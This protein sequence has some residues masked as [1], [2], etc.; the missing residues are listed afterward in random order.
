MILQF[1]LSLNIIAISDLITHSLTSS[2]LISSL[3]NLGPLY[4]Q[5]G[6]PARHVF[7][8][9]VAE[10]STELFLP[11]RI[12]LSDN[13]IQITETDRLALIRQGLVSKT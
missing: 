6:V 5:H 11:D 13:T 4:Q 12:R 8:T 3:H 10:K 9:H 2:F 7:W 1:L